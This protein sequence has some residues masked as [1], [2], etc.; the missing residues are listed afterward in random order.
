[1]RAL[2]SLRSLW[3]DEDEVPEDLSKPISRS[4]PGYAAIEAER[5]RR[6]RVALDYFGI[7]EPPTAHQRARLFVAVHIVFPNAFRVA[8][9]RGPKAAADRQNLKLFHWVSENRTVQRKTDAAVLRHTLSKKKLFALFPWLDGME[10]ESI[11]NGV[12]AGK[13]LAEEEERWE[14]ERCSRMPL[15]HNPKK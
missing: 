11:L 14:A 10:E 9:K 8:N 12:S 2:D 15:S 5:L 6:F 7:Q 13:R 1:V 4:L 3:L